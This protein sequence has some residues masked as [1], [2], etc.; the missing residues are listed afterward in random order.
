M[1][2]SD[3]AFLLLNQINNLGVV[4]KINCKMRICQRLNYD[5][6]QVSFFESKEIRIKDEW[7]APKTRHFFISFIAEIDY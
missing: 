6:S 2:L 3:K 7:D 1:K 4:D 5:D